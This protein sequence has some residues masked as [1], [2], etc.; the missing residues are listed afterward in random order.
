ME[1]SKQKPTV[2]IPIGKGR[3]TNIRCA[4]TFI[5]L[6]IDLLDCRYRNNY[7]DYYLYINYFLIY[8]SFGNGKGNRCSLKVRLIS[9]QY[10]SIIA[11]CR[12]PEL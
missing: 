10:L 3:N 11:K 6:E 4:F 7:N 1:N 8:H 5:I 2:R 9:R 12:N